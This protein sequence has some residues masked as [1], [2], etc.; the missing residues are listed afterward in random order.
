VPRARTTVSR[1]V[2]REGRQRCRRNGF[3]TPSLCRAHRTV[4]E[5]VSSPPEQPLGARVASVLGSFLRGEKV[6]QRAMAEGLAEGIFL[7]AMAYRAYKTGEVHRGSFPDGVPTGFPGF[8]PPPRRPRPPPPP[9]PDP[10]VRAGHLAVLGFPPGATPT[11]DEIQRRRRD[12]ALQNHPDRG[13]SPERMAAINAAA[14]AL[15]DEIG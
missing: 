8:P 14:D 7:G 1:C 12:L 10:R 13:G 4:F 2:Y 5:H 9:G 6:N 3:G 11:A 15:V